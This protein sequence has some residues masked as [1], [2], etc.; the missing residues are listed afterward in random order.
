[1]I[2]S[3]PSSSK[4]PRHSIDAI[5]P[6]MAVDESFFGRPECNGSRIETSYRITDLR[7]VPFSP[8]MAQVLTA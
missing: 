4:K 8:E 2:L 6:G 7:A 3:L 1:M 5:K